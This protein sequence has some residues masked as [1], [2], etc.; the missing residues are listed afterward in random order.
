MVSQ[1]QFREDLYYLL[2][3]MALLIVP[4]RYRHNDISMTAKFLLEKACKKY[5]K[6]VFDYNKEFDRTIHTHNW[7]GNAQELE[8]L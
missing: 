6:T 5:H 4:L 7:P 3:V 8:I 2:H 1:S